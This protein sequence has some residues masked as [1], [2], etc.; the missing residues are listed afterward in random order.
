MVP[1]VKM[2]LESSAGVASGMMIEP[3]TATCIKPDV[4]ID[5]V[6][7]TT[8]LRGALKSYDGLFMRNTMTEPLIEQ[9]GANTTIF[10]CNIVNGREVPGILYLVEINSE[11]E[12]KF[13]AMRTG[14]FSM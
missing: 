8:F 12:G 3:T 1:P 4:E 14:W 7:K 10:N 5:H 9:H 2:S 11:D 6:G 13:E